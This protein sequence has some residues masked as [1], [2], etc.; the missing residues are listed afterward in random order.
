MFTVTTSVFTSPQC[1]QSQRT[2]LHHPVFTV[3]TSKFTI[4]SVNSLQRLQSTVHNVNIYSLWSLQRLQSTVF[5]VYSVFSLQFSV[6]SVNK[7]TRIKI[8][9]NLIKTLSKPLFGRIK[10][11]NNQFINLS[12]HNIYIYFFTKF[13]HIIKNK[14]I[15]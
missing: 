3:T 7:G 12:W 5:T 14:K 1:L 9:L 11:Q 4:F 15:I 8:N 13:Y 6:Y 10:V 2:C